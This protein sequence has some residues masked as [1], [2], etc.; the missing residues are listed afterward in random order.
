MRYWRS[1][2]WS[3]ARSN[4][5]HSTL[6][7]YSTV[8]SPKPVGFCLFV[9]FGPLGSL[10]FT[11]K[12]WSLTRRCADDSSCLWD[13]F[14]SC[15]CWRASMHCQCEERFWMSVEGFRGILRCMPGLITKTQVFSRWPKTHT[16]VHMSNHVSGNWTTKGFGV[17]PVA[18]CNQPRGCCAFF[19]HLYL[20]SWEWATSWG[21]PSSV[22]RFS[23]PGSICPWA[24]CVDFGTQLSYITVLRMIP[25]WFLCAVVWQP[26]A[27]FKVLHAPWVC[28]SLTWTTIKRYSR[29]RIQFWFGTGMFGRYGSLASFQPA[30][31][32]WFAQWLI[33]HLLCPFAGDLFPSTSWFLPSP[34]HHWHFWKRKGRAD[35]A[36]SMEW[37]EGDRWRAGPQ[38]LGIL[39]ICGQLQVSWWRWQEIDRVVKCRQPRVVASGCVGL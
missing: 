26:G 34:E 32:E 36:H 39:C 1:L 10:I 12:P 3:N 5:R 18:F 6:G 15:W 22:A 16:G 27:R 37:R 11:R 17:S 14:A 31:S 19:V 33:K 4:T 30:R 20:F 28:E 25:W 2:L 21:Y 29:C 8:Y 35:K 23:R 13:G 38:F 7:I 24:H 9:W